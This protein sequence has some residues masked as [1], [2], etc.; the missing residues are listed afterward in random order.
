MGSVYVI[1]YAL[2]GGYDSNNA[3]KVIW[4]AKRINISIPDKMSKEIQKVKEELIHDR[5]LSKVCQDAIRTV[6]EV[7][8]VSKIYRTEGRNEGKT[9]I[10]NIAIEH[11]EY[12]AR[13]LSGIG[14][15]KKWSKYEKV[16]E[17]EDRFSSPKISKAK[18]PKP[19]KFKDLMSGRIILH[20][21]VMHSDE[22]VSADRRSEMTWSYIEGY[23][24]G[25]AKAYIDSES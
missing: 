11:Q 22:T 24:E 5:R 8:R 9:A 15:Y 6:L 14:P 23:Y 19:T 21:W 1:I 18:C 7:A 4:M 20:D 10:R 3:T 16:Q 2:I 12:I 13:V 17:L 25:I